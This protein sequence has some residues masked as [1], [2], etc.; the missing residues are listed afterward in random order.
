VTYPYRAY[1]LTL[2]C[3]TPVSALREEAIDLLR[4]VHDELAIPLH[5]VGGL[6]HLPQHRPGA[7]G[8]HRMRLEQERRHDAGGPHRC[9]VRVADLELHRDGALLVEHAVTSMMITPRAL[10]L[11]GLGDIVFL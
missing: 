8:V 5:D 6:V 1:G 9:A 10:V 11:F 3:D 4:R 2:S 7:H